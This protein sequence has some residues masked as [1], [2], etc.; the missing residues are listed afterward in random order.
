MRWY[1]FE[2]GSKAQRLE[3]C[4]KFV[5]HKF[6][7]IHVQLLAPGAGAQADNISRIVLETLNISLLNIP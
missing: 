7:Y 3:L 1:R 4:R 5:D 2:G 6:Q